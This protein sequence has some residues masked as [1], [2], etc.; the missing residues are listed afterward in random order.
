MTAVSTAWPRRLGSR[1]TW[2]AALLFAA[3]A[4]AFAYPVSLH[5]ASLRFPAGPDENLGWYLIGWNTHSFVHHPWSIFEANIYY[6]Q[7]NTLAYGENII[8]IALFVA[9]IVWLTGNPM[10]A[11][12]IAAILSCVLCGLGTYV[13][14]RRVGLS[15]AA[16][17]IAGIIF[18]C[19]PP[20][21]YRILQINLSNIQW[22]PFALAALHAYLDTG[23]RRFLLWAVTC[24]TLE[25][26]S[27]GHGAVFMA[28][29]L[30]IFGLYRV[31]LGEPWLPLKRVRD[32]GVTGVL[33][34]LPS[35]LAYLPYRAV[36]GEVGLRR[37]LGSWDLQ[38]RSFFASPSHLHQFLQKALGLEWINQ[39][40]TAYLFPGC[41]ALLLV[42][43]ALAWRRRS[44]PTGGAGENASRPTGAPSPAGP[45]SLPLDASRAAR[46]GAAR[47]AWTR[48]ARVLTIGCGVFLALAVA[49]ALYGHP[50]RFRSANDELLFSAKDPWRAVACA[51]VLLAC[52]LALVRRAP[53]TAPGWLLLLVAALRRAPAL[54]RRGAAR[55]RVWAAFRRH[56]ATSFFLVLTAL[57][58]G[59]A[60]GPP[61]GLWRY[62]FRWP[63]FS[64]IRANSRFSLVMMLGIA[65]L[66]GIGFDRVARRLRGRGRVVL[67]TICGL[68]LVA[69]YAVMPMR[70][71]A[72]HF[73]IPAIDRWLDTRP[74]PFVVAEVPV[75]VNDE[76]L[77][78]AY[79]LHSMAH[80]Q[81][82]VHGYSGWRAALH[83]Q[84]YDAL[85]LFPDKES[86]A[87][88]TELDVTYLVAHT[89]LYPPGEWEKVDARIAQY[90]PWL[91]LEHVE[92]TGRVYSV[93]PPPKGA[94][95]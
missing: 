37:G 17:I 93:H 73:E 76:H 29:T 94:L 1:D 59:L 87:W 68:V 8:G 28:V 80:W 64:F 70:S 36:Q 9:P 72:A 86:L 50:V 63:G 14:A 78:A 88:L 5:P 32:F 21:F 79:M 77:Q 51:G 62:V 18:E 46:F 7:H 82:T 24:V 43:I 34:L 84:L 27:S 71:E 11:T 53:L 2:L 26:L 58:F 67:A 40:A 49:H 65:I 92:G 61:Y 31:L 23:R 20:R 89:E 55:A 48:L 13:L 25:T 10:M 39:T 75:R 60:L 44:E 52:R 35:A 56:D 69:E 42:A 15:V 41:L 74:K 33:L 81:K 45:A 91:R 83:Y 30:L 3:L 6:P 47:P 12:T 85:A 54:A 57:G 4:I 16:A 95:H 38:F 90:W 19:A 22:I 66:A